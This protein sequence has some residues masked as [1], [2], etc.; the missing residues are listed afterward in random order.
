MNASVDPSPRTSMP[1]LRLD[2][3]RSGPASSSRA[4][5]CWTGSK[6]RILASTAR[7]GAP[8]DS[9]WPVERTAWSAPSSSAKR[10][11]VTRAPERTVTVQ[12]TPATGWALA[13]LHRHVVPAPLAGVDLARPGD[14]LLGVV[15]HLKPLGDPTRRPS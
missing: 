12:G 9:S 14:L 15:D 2:R 11:R 13:L 5:T 6:R 3:N 7:R 4:A 8:P 10:L 1:A